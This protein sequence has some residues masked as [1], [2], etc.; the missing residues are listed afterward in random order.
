MNG[1]TMQPGIDLG[2]GRQGLVAVLD[3]GAKIGQGQ[4]DQ[5][6][7]YLTQCDLQPTEELVVD[8]RKY[9]IEDF[10]KQIQWD[11]PRN[12]DREY[13]WTLIC[14]TTYL[15]TDASWP[16]QDGEEWS[17][18]RLVEIEL[19]HEL[20]ASA[21]GG[22]HR[23]VGLTTAL[24]RHLARQGK[25][26]GVWKETDA[27]IQAAIEAA[28]TFQNP[29]TGLFPRTISSG[30]AH[31]PT[32]TKFRSDRAHAGVSDAGHDIGATRTGVG[33]AGSAPA[34]RPAHG[35]SRCVAGMRRT[36][37]RGAW[38]GAL[39]RADVRSTDLQRG[40][41]KFLNANEPAH[42]S[43]ARSCRCFPAEPRWWPRW[44]S[45]RL[46]SAVRTSAIFRPLY[47]SFRFAL[48]RE[49]R[50]TDQAGRLTT[51]SVRPHAIGAV[52]LRSPVGRAD[53]PA[54]GHHHHADTMRRMRGR[55][56]DR[57]SGGRVTRWL[58]GHKSWPCA[59]QRLSE[60][61]LDIER[62]AAAFDGPAVW[63]PARD[64]PAAALGTNANP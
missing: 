34:L 29:Q 37:S 56:T 20:G 11:V 41:Y 21:C 19:S 27:K 6:L 52:D 16:A 1:W 42:E 44:V 46:S 2:N 36:V 22:S 15:P 5:W 24:N 61:W 45:S 31:R 39:P 18:E 30:Q 51:K 54:T 14:L 28:R 4:P 32:G 58:R 53:S 7:A 49:F 25:L 8:G 60:I 50:C 13:S 12:V 47:K 38:P 63:Q 26:E 35:D 40:A 10:I 59:V 62:V 64:R 23:L 48:S 55:S 57:G 43:A 3:P 17:I 9:T 33:A